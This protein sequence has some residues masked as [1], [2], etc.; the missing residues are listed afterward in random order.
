VLLKKGVS[1]AGRVFLNM[2]RL[3][4]L[5]PDTENRSLKIPLKLDLLFPL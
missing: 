2:V 5:Q 1:F 4:G 3:H